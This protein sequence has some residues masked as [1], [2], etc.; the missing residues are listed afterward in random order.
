MVPAAGLHLIFGATVAWVTLVKMTDKLLNPISV[1]WR[2]AQV[3]MPE[4][5]LA[6]HLI[7]QTG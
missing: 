1:S 7:Q 6:T 4:P 5:T 3:V 2:G